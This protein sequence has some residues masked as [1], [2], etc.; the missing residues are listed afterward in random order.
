MRVSEYFITTLKEAPAEAEMVSH[1]L[2]LRAGLVRQLGAGLYHWLPLGLRVLRNVENIIREELNALGAMELLMPMVHPNDIWQ[3]TKRW[4]TFG[5]EL[6]KIKDRHERDLCLAPTHEEAITSIMANELQSYKQLPLV[7][8]QIQTK[9]R[10]EPRPR[11]GLLRG[12]EFCMK[13][14]YSF[15]VSRESLEETYQKIRQAYI[16]I[17]TRLGLPFRV[18][19]ADTGSIGGYFS[20][21]FHIIAPSG[22]DKLVISDSSDYCANIEVANLN[23]GDPSPDGNGK[24]Q[25]ARGIEVG[26]IFQLGDKY[27]RDMNATVLDQ[28]GKT[29][30]VEMGCYGI[31]VSRIVAAAIEQNHDD[32]GIIWPESMAPFQVA[33]V[34]INM[35]KSTR[36]REEAEKIY[37]ELTDNGISVLFNDRNE[38]PGVMFAE[39]ELIGI[40]HRIV[41]SDRGLENNTLEYRK[42]S[43]SENENIPYEIDGVV[44]LLNAH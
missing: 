27:S 41:V 36:V 30:F 34:P 31:G 40:P 25:F 7:L 38:R 32:N 26:H 11:S 18:A 16:N 39:M 15:H 37:R 44:A 19:L 24:V 21:E 13:D 42:R 8:Y 6:L 20:E 12:R 1:R 17:F 28:S 22:E 33:L 43:A 10:D 35:H 29:S 4:D 5:P 3:T 9:F 2:S 14:A 23:E